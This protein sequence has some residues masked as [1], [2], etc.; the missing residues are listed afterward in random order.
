MTSVLRVNRNYI[1]NS[2]G[3]PG[4]HDRT[5]PGSFPKYNLITV[6][7]G[8]FQYQGNSYSNSDLQGAETSN[9]ELQY[10]VPVITLMLSFTSTF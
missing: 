4:L 3:C 7:C 6:E 10:L 1:C 5:G 9:S 8:N 2:T